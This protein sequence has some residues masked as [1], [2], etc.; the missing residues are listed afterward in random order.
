MSNITRIRLRRDIAANWAG[1]NP[2]LANGEVGLET[3]TRNI[4]VGDGTTAYVALPYWLNGKDVRGQASKMDAGTITIAETGAYVSTG[5]TATFDAATAFGMSL[6]TVDAF[7]LKNTSGGTKLLRFFGSIDAAAGNNETLGI[8]LALNGVAIAETECRAF[9]ASAVA[10][11]KLVTS[12]MIELD[13]GDEVSLLIANH[14]ST[15]TINFQ[16][17]RIIASEVR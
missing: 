12:W 10:V 9:K 16:R 11:A 15:T 14:T 1:A 8:K 6:G 2:V 17:G 5:L 7:G 13:D 3:D 4:K